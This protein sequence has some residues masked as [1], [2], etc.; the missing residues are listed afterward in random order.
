MS[1]T[2]LRVIIAGGGIAGLA[3]ANMLEKANIDYILLEAYSQIAPQVGASIALHPNGLRILDQLGCYEDILKGWDLNLMAVPE[4]TR[5]PGGHCLQKIYAMKEHMKRR[6]G[7]PLVVTD[8][9]KVQQTLYDSLEHKERVLLQKRVLQVT[10]TEDGVQVQTVDGDTVSGHVLVGADGAHSKVRAEMRRIA[11]ESN[12]EYFDLEEESQVP[13]YY[14]CL[15]GVSEYV[16]GSDIHTDFVA[17]K[18]FSHLVV[19]APRG[20]VFFIATEK[21]EGGVTRGSHVPRYTKEDEQSFVERRSNDRLTPTATFGDVYKRKQFSV[22]TPLHEHVY[23]RW[24]F[25][26]IMTIGDAAHKQSPLS[27]QGGNCAIED[28]AVLVNALLRQ[29]KPH[30]TPS[31]ELKSG[32]LTSLDVEKAFAETQAQCLP[33]ASVLVQSGHLAQAIFGFENLPFSHLV[34]RIIRA[35]GLEGMIGTIS[36]PYADAPR[37]EML[38]MPKRLHTVPYTDELPAK[39]V[40]STL[41][42][43]GLM[44]L[45]A[46]LL[47]VLAYHSMTSGERQADSLGAWKTAAGSEESWLAVQ[48]MAIKSLPFLLAPAL[49]WPLDANRRGNSASIPLFMAA[50]FA[51]TWS[52]M[53][54]VV[55]VP[56]VYFLLNAVLGDNSIVGRGIQSDVAATFMPAISVAAILPNAIGGLA[57]STNLWW[58]QGQQRGGI[59]LHLWTA[60]LM[61][62]VLLVAGTVRLV[63]VHQSRVSKLESP[64]DLAARSLKNY[65]KKDL[66]P[67]MQC[68][69]LVLAICSSVHV[70]SMIYALKTGH[71]SCAGFTDISCWVWELRRQGYID[72]KQAG[73]AALSIAVGQTL[74]GPGAVY[75]AAWRWREGVLANLED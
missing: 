51:V 17:G 32:L 52:L 37:L 7:Y 56:P 57:H 11:N 62:G 36:Q 42:S 40:T 33:R 3:L 54:G 72:T 14:K 29:M 12:P 41:T 67:L 63:Q 13:A 26:R 50:V 20:R 61:C 10:T 4:V 64:S 69:G 38:P 35:G 47:C 44:A 18:N 75:V 25:R 49:I 24:H 21:M 15:F 48:E 19:T 31:G 59:L 68:Y 8:R 27:G 71:S 60:T 53:G 73:Q 1:D 45:T 43:G 46:A 70:A 6:Y 2:G 16:P 22:L 74:V 23:K 66:Q 9:Q 5:W 28:G 34:F 65:G 30:I 55:S 39:P 58:Q